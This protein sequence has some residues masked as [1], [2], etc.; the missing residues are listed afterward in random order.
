MRIG[1]REVGLEPAIHRGGLTAGSYAQA[2]E[3]LGGKT[4]V[5]S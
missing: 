5:G 1:A 4:K 3:P 2:M